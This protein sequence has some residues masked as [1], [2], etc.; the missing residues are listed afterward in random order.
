MNVTVETMSLTTLRCPNCG[1]SIDVDGSVR[2][3]L[4]RFGCVRCGARLS[5]GDFRPA[6]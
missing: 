3:A 6:A 4:L 1:E 2:A 5:P